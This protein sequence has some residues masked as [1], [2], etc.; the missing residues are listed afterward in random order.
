MKKIVA[1]L[2]MLTIIISLT[3]AALAATVP[4]TKTETMKITAVVP[5]PDYTIHV[6]ENTT[7]TYGDTSAAKNLGS[8]QVSDVKNLTTVK[9]TVSGTSLKNGTNY[10]S[11]KYEWKLGSNQWEYAWVSDGSNKQ[12]CTCELYNAGAYHVLDM[13]AYVL[14]WSPAVPGEYTATLTYNFVGE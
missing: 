7:M 4:K 6:P 14:T 3:A 1:L 10:I 12:L 9:C 5:E 11:I 13:K 8:V 2:L